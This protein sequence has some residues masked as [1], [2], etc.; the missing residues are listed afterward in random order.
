MSGWS[1]E[2]AVHILQNKCLIEV[3]IEGVHWRFEM[4]DHLR[5]LG[6]QLANDLVPRRLWKPDILK[7]MEEK[8]FEHILAETKAR[9][10]NSFWDSSLESNINYFV[11]S[12]NDY[13]ETE[14]LWLEIN[15]DGGA[16]KQIPS[17]IP[18]RKLHYLF[19]SEMDEI[20]NRFQQQM[21][22]NTQATFEFRRLHIFS[23]L[24]NA[25]LQGFKSL[26]LKTLELGQLQRLNILELQS[27]YDL[28]TISGLSSL[29]GL[30]SLHVRQCDKL[31]TISD[32]SSLT[33]LESLHVQR[34]YVLETIFRLSSVTGLK[35]LHVQ[36]CPKCEIRFCEDFNTLPTIANLCNLEE[37]A[38]LG[39]GQ[40]QSVQGFEE[41]KDLRRLVLKVSE[42]GYAFVRNCVNGLRRLPSEYTV[43]IGTGY[44]VDKMA[45][46]MRC[47]LHVYHVIHSQART[48]CHIRMAWAGRFVR[49][50]AIA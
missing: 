27:C 25:V 24:S 30:Q 14:L 2:H 49:Y 31:K 40:V 50:V 33:R 42:N 17:W 46:P 43:L 47:L 37:I 22:S 28:Q 3:K 19:V 20:W 5:D 15:K 45:R 44:A 4:H 48:I 12:L 11:G 36:E 38:I 23:T 16:L 41:L 21:Q 29:T 34:C 39:C 26:Q 8:G 18:L 9:C 10:F 7:S 32:L 35:S 1:A 6:R 13:G